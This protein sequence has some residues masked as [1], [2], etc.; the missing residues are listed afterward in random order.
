MSRRIRRKFRN[1]SG[2]HL[3]AGL[4]SA[5]GG[6]ARAV[7]YAMN[8]LASITRQ[9]RR[10]TAF[11]EWVSES[12][13]ALELGLT[14]EESQDWVDILNPQAPDRDVWQ[15]MT[16]AVHSAAEKHRSDA[17]VN[18]VLWQLC[19]AM[20]LD[21]IDA[22]ILQ[23]FIDYSTCRVTGELWNRLSDA[24][25]E[26]CSL[27]LDPRFVGMILNRP[28]DEIAERLGVGGPLRESGLLRIEHNSGVNVLPKLQFLV[29]QTLVESIDVKSA[30]LGP[31][32]TTNM[33]LDDFA[34]LG[35]DI[36]QIMRVLRG[37]LQVRGR[38]IVICLY[39]PPGTGKT[40][41]AITLAAALGIPLHS[42]G[43]V[44]D[45]G[46]EPTRDDR[47]AELQIAQRLL[48]NAELSMLL[49][50]EAED[51]FGDGNDLVMRL[52]GARRSVGSKAFVHK[53]LENCNAPIIM[54]ANSLKAFG[55]A[56]LRRM[57]V[58]LEVRI[59]PVQVRTRIWERAAH[60]NGIEVEAEQLAVLARQLPAAPAVAASAMKAARLA[61]GNPETIRWA[62]GGVVKAMN[63]GKV[64]SRPMMPEEFDVR[65]VNADIDILALADNLSR[66][67][68]P[69]NWGMLL[70]GPSGAGKTVF[71]R[72]LAE[73]LGL[74]VVQKRSSDILGKY[75]GE[76]ERNIAAAFAEALDA[77]AVLVF[78]ECDSLIQ[79]R[80]GA[81]RNWEVSQVNEFL[82]WAESHPL[83]L[84]CTTNLLSRI[85]PAAM[86][87]FLIKAEFKPLTK[88]QAAIAFKKFF[89]TDA[90]VALAQLDKLTPA[91]FAV[92]KRMAELH[93]KLDD[94]GFLISLLEKEQVAKYGAKKEAIGFL[95]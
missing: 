74:E 3:G 25:G 85:D 80:R 83:P 46:R 78:D 8:V 70:A 12:N 9:S 81:H 79:D 53:L 47:L 68:A 87:R 69:K 34:H 76:T 21:C 72:H 19:K 17:D 20:C 29:R 4:A 52:F 22:A 18:P 93:G 60:E 30:L 39:G 33:C 10:G 40:Q 66:P 41:L 82:T 26:N 64:S 5:P 95:H 49:V 71:V 31:R 48:A 43:E 16:D 37:A 57:T 51:L 15:R 58:C 89:N 67:D 36:H 90:P 84:C 23:L 44:D 35:D 88:G 61:G 92:A 2:P 91:D 63:G 32:C 55:P 56:V 73:R 6:K 27:R 14:D 45:E 24:E 59:P 42:V 28:E 1:H 11:A 62:L 7:V 50:D 94:S 75:V 13:Y 86:R 65:L 38:G 54:T 77:N